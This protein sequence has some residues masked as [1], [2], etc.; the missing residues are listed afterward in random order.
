MTCHLPSLCGSCPREGRGILV[1][2]KGKKT[3]KSIQWKPESS[4]V[5][6][7]LFELDEEERANVFKL[8]SFEEMRKQELAREKQAGTG[9]KGSQME[10]EE[11]REENKEEKIWTMRPIDF[12]DPEQET[13]VVKIWECYGK[14]SQEKEVQL[15]REGRVLKSLFFNS[16][17]TDPAEPDLA[18]R[19]GDPRAVVK[20]IPGEDQSCEGEDSADSVVDH[21]MKGWPAPM[22]KEAA[23]DSIIRGGQKTG[24]QGN[25]PAAQPP[26][27]LPLNISA[28]LQ[29]PALQSILGGQNVNTPPPTLKPE[30]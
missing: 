10:E 20:D 26:N 11:A 28:M 17:P 3:K 4:L 22:D 21:S 27:G 23:F 8:K 30:G 25:V 9:M 5:E 29:D 12:Q 14:D 16:L 15:E 7:K 18:D 6:V 1:L 19:G 2:V 13:H 24:S